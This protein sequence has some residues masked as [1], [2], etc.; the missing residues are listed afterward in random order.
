M[1]PYV[2]LYL[3]LCRHVLMNV[4]M[5]M[6]VYVAFFSPFHQINVSFWLMGYSYLVF[7][8]WSVKLCTL[9]MWTYYEVVNELVLSEVVTFSPFNLIFYLRS[10]LFPCEECI[11]KFL[12]M[13]DIQI[14]KL[15]ILS[16]LSC[17]SNIS[18]CFISNVC[19][20]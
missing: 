8:F 19:G 12:R 18:F 3:C 14:D 2:W 10:T 16:I 4:H 5:C 1:H 15:F 11:F 9:V 17:V 20:N 7:Q 6:H 13:R